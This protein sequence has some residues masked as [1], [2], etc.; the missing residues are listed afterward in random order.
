MKENLKQKV[1]EEFAYVPHASSS[2]EE[3]SRAQKHKM[4]LNKSVDID[5]NVS[6][7][8]SNTDKLDQTVS[9]E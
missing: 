9:V 2:G 5:P 7:I 1:K 6:I 8:S 4:L 3:E